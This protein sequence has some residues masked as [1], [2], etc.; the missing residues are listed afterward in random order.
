MHLKSKVLSAVAGFT[1]L[2]ALA[3]SAAIA[4]VGDTGTTQ[5]TVIISEGGAFDARFCQSQAGLVLN[6]APTSTTA[7]NA[8]GGMFICYD[9]TVSYR[10]GFVSQITSSTFT[11]LT[12]NSVIPSSNF[13]ITRTWAVSSIQS[14]PAST[15]PIGDIDPLAESGAVSGAFV[16]PWN[17]PNNTLDQARY[18]HAAEAGVGTIES[19]GQVDLSLIVPVGTQA[20]IYNSTVTLTILPGLP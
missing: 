19:D 1:L 9:D 2:L 3:A 14:N 15:L 13:S 17:G 6:S 10:P 5:A 7:G 12:T 20:G 4:Q 8:T 11:S 16:T 18:V